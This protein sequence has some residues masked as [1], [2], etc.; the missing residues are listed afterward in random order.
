MDADKKT[1]FTLRVRL[2]NGEVIEQEI[3]SSGILICELK[4]LLSDRTEIPV[5]RMRLMLGSD[6]L[7]DDRTLESYNVIDSSSVL[8]L[9]QLAGAQAARPRDVTGI[10]AANTPPPSLGPRSNPARQIFLANPQLA[11]TLMMANPQMREA[12]ENN[13]ELRNLMRDPQ[14]MQQSLDA[15]QN[16]QLMQEV[17]RNNDRVLSNL[18]SAP[19]GYAHIRRMYHS[20]QEPLSRVA[21][22]STRMPLDELNQRRA[23]MLGV[24][25]PDMAKVNT[26]PL[27]N[28]WARNRQRSSTRPAADTRN[29]FGMFDQV[30][31][32][33]DRLA[34]LDISTNQQPTSR[35]SARP[36][37]Q[38]RP[39]M[40]RSQA[41]F[42]DLSSFASL[43]QQE[44]HQHQRHSGLASR[45]SALPE[46]SPRPTQ[47][48][49]MSI[50]NPDIASTHTSS[51]TAAATADNR[52]RFRHELDQLEEMGFSDEDK[53]LR[54]L[55]ETDG[56][57]DSAL[58]IIAGES[59]D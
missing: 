44:Q 21:E 29:P 48:S 8:R 33:A 5:A 19:G 20:I 17:Q 15:V 12:M 26:T 45:S 4:Q 52:D 51:A 56:D 9:V 39:A 10:T 47:M 11:Q 3:S 49:A 59:D 14:I 24:T 50:V 42:G 37:S 18:E 43:L 25:K 38:E 46:S 13:P 55:I 32:N 40:P 31:R 30:S 54:A 23:R 57:L 41:Q 36:Y 35:Q 7:N 53:N 58:T 1:E 27:P 2:T 6:I 28:P 16:P 34:R 22:D